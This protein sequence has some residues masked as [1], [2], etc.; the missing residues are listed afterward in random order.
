MRKIFGERAVKLLTLLLAV[1][2]HRIAAAMAPYGFTP[3]VVHEGF[4]L[5]E[6]LAGKRADVPAPPKPP[7]PKLLDA[8]D[9]WENEWLPISDMSLRRHAPAVRDR[10]FLDLAHGRDAQVSVRIFTNRIKALENGTPEEKSARA[11]LAERGLTTE[12][13]DEAVQLL[14]L[15]GTVAEPTPAPA[16]DPA[17]IE[18][19]EK[20]AWDYYLEWST[21]ARRAISDRRLLIRMGV[22][23]DDDDVDSV[24]E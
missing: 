9:A 12:V 10:V 24:A 17:E 16:I 18:A 1:R 11:L 14:D 13:V 8:I 2:E 21:V 23:L 20:A 4:Q 5:L 6:D 22:N 7:D 3:D 15:A 19:A